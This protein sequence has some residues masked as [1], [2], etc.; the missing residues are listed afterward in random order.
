MTKQ[1][2]PRYNRDE[3][4][5]ILFPRDDDSRKTMFPL[6]VNEHPA[7]ANLFLVQS[8]IE[9]VSEPEQTLMDIMAGTGTIIVGALIGRQVI[10]IEISD[11]FAGLINRAAAQLDV[12]APG[13]A[14]Q[15]TVINAPCQT[16]LPIPNIADHIVFSPQYASILKKGAGYRE[17]DKFTVEQMGA[18]DFTEYS[19]SPLNLGVMNDFLWANTMETIYDKCFKSIRP[20]GSMTLIVK[21]HMRNRQRVFLTQ[22][23][24]DMCTRIGFVLTDW[25]KWKAP[26][27]AYTSIRRA[28]GEE[29]VE[30]ESII[31]LKKPLTIHVDSSMSVSY[32]APELVGVV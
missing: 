23:A 2:A 14:N 25:F 26:G 9:Y 22:A 4:G 21:D 32:H 15:I 27:L 17:T 1:F 7:K 19:K 3:N 30:D 12:I 5:W 11:K 6:E 20:G 31:I 13:A 28:R 8:V 16:V 29:V 18:Y 24:V 10:C